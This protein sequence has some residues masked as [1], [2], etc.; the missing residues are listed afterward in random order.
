M[1]VV[2]EKPSYA[3]GETVH[4]A[5]YMKAME[6]LDCKAVHLDFIGREDVGKDGIEVEERSYEGEGG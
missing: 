2:L 6:H 3:P 4:G 1:Q 5:I